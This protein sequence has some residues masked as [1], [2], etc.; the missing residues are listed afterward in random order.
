MILSL[1]ILDF[2]EYRTP[3]P[4]LENSINIRAENI[5]HLL[6]APQLLIGDAC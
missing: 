2:T 5:Q 6:G 4:C 1:E 3:T